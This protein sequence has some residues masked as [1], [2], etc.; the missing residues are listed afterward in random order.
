MF[1]LVPFVL[2]VASAA[3]A[4]GVPRPP[5]FNPVTD[6]PHTVGQPGYIGPTETAPR[7]PHKRVLPPTKEQG[8]WAGDAPKASIEP[9]APA[10]VDGILLPYPGDA[11]ALADVHVI[12]MCASMM[13]HAMRRAGVYPIGTHLTSA[14]REC[15]AA[16]YLLDCATFVRDGLMRSFPE[17][18]T[19]HDKQVEH[20]RAW[21]AAKCTAEVRTPEVDAINVMRRTWD[22]H[23]A[24]R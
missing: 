16:A 3:S 8:L 19:A 13:P 20:A 17:K 2:L 9:L 21:H 12:R 15:I 4:Q 23:E 14:Q 18:P 24:S 1:R 10:Y 7:S 5:A 22:F 6:S 11:V